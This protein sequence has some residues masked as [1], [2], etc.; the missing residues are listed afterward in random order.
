MCA[1]MKYK[2][3]NHV[4]INDIPEIRSSGTYS[5]NP[6][7]MPENNCYRISSPNSTSEFFIVEYRKAE[8]LYENNLPGSGLLIYRID[9]LVSGNATGPPDE[10]YIYR[11]NGTHSMNGSPSNAF[12]SFGSTRTSIN[13]ATNP[14]CFLQNGDPGGLQIVDIGIAGSTIT[15]SV[16][17]NEMIPPSGFVTTATGPGEV[18]LVWQKNPDHDNVLLVSNNTNGFGTPVKGA[19]YGVG[20]IIPGGGTVIYNGSGEEFIH[21]GLITNT[22]YF[23]RIFS[24]TAG[25]TYSNAVA[26]QATT[27]CG[28]YILPFSESFISGS[29][30]DCWSYQHSEGVIDNWD[31]SASTY[32]GGSGNEL[33]STF[34]Q[35]NSGTTRIVTPMINTIGMSKLELSFR[36]TLDDWATG[37]TLRI[38]SSSD[39]VNWTPEPW[40]LATSSNTTI[41]PVMIHTTIEHNLD[42]PHTYL[43]FTIEGNLYKYDFWYI[44]DIL[45]KCASVL[46]V[47]LT[48][49]GSPAEGGNVGGGGT[50]LFGEPVTISASPKPGWQFLGWTEGNA[51][52]STEEIL[53]I[54][55]A[56]R[57]LLAHF[58]NTEANI[59]L[60][61]E[62]AEGGTTSGGGIY[63]LGSP[64]T[65][66]AIPKNGYAFSGWMQNGVLVA[67]TAAYSFPVSG[68]THLIA[69]FYAVVTPSYRVVIE[70][71]R[72]E[73]GIISGGGTFNE[74]TLCTVYASPFPDWIFEGWKEN[75]VTRSF[76]PDYTFTVDRDYNLKAIFRQELNIR[77]EVFPM[78]A[79][80][81]MGAGNYLTGDT[82]KCLAAYNPG[83]KFSKWTRNGVEVS[84][85][86]LYSFIAETDCNLEAVFVSGVGEPEM[87]WGGM[88]VFPNPSSGTVFI[89]NTGTE[90]LKEI[91]I[92]SISGQVVLYSSMAGKN[93]PYSAD[94][95]DL[96]VGLYT[97]IIHTVTGKEIHSK[98]MLVNN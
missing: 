31:V 15:F 38:Q 54:P 63:M 5:L 79:G 69:Q 6:I 60:S 22:D 1:W 41:G 3:S 24:V 90:V 34:Q 78:L 74:G 94:L 71:S 30:P 36:S 13:D 28:A 76:R 46:P 17:I 16:Y 9:T 73:G 14:G 27:F 95:S 65:I 23:Y 83:W 58:S 44:D 81:A 87:E 33:R 80:Q 47:Q 59:V 86:S 25:N 40:M 39:G 35:V 91:K 67:Q 50:Y 56:Q 42:S 77:T 26:S 32:A 43:A 93:N 7:D 45:V 51:T 49:S 75:G 55:A 48:V 8:G 20:E 64:A 92:C 11:P 89:K 12:F 84:A 53:T 29:V 96:P 61:A 85:D 97:I 70:T 82:V 66:H 72:S 10:V 2:Y 19:V 18:Q 37:A 57:S 88:T 68:T 62:P 4:W 52:V 98:L 21:S